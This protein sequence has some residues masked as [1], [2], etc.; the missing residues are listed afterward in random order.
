MTVG[1][2]SLSLRTY[3]SPEHVF[4][5]DG[6]VSNPYSDLTPEQRRARNDELARRPTRRLR[7]EVD[8]ARPE[9]LFAP[10]QPVRVHL[11]WDNG[12]EELYDTVAFGWTG[13]YVQVDVGRTEYTAPTVWL[14]AEDV[15][16]R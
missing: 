6:M 5:S 13:G 8:T 12:R 1:G 2:A 3:R 7:N 9:H 4:Y 14:R 16:R 11:I 15:V 10:P